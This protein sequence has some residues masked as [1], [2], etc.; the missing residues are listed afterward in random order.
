MN[1][2]HDEKL[3]PRANRIIHPRKGNDIY[4]H[5]KTFVKLVSL[6]VTMNIRSVFKYSFHATYHI[7]YELL[8]NILQLQRDLSPQ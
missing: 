5:D 6:C 4:I 2:E 1:S 3:D 8:I 7:K